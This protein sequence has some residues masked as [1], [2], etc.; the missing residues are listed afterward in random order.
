MST[1]AKTPKP[2]DNSSFFIVRKEGRSSFGTRDLQRTL[3]R[4]KARADK[5][6]GV[7]EKGGKVVYDS[8]S[9]PKAKAF[10]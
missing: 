1:I 10:I 6:G 7:V 2:L 5:V 4:A 8:K 9:T 3:A